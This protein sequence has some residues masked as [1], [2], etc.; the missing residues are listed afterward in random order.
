MKRLFLFSSPRKRHVY[1]K[2]ISTTDISL[3]LR[4]ESNDGKIITGKYS[5]PRE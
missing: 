2:K 4:L 1:G 5:G 3:F